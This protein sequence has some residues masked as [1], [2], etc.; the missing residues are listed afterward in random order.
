MQQSCSPFSNGNLWTC[1]PLKDSKSRHHQVEAKAFAIQGLEAF[2]AIAGGHW[3]K[4][5]Q[6]ITKAGLGV[7][8]S[9]DTLWT[10]QCELFSFGKNLL[11]RPDNSLS[12][13]GQVLNKALCLAVLNI[14]VGGG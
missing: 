7:G 5:L 6:L 4:G 13:P 8:L 1:E 3:E 12:V 10:S 9:T 2:H 11:A 14:C